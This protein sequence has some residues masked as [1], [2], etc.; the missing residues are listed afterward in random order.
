MPINKH[1]QVY[2]V[3]FQLSEVVEP[4]I[5]AATKNM[6]AIININPPIVEITN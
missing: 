1:T 4:I 2:P 6:T 5:I 3:D